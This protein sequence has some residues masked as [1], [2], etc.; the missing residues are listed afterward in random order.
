MNYT[1]VVT[2]GAGYASKVLPSSEAA[3]QELTG[4]RP[5]PG[6]LNLRT[7]RD[8]ALK[9]GLRFQGPDDG[10][11]RMLYPALLG[12]VEVFINRWSGCPPNRID[13]LADKHLR[14]EL[15]LLDGSKIMVTIADQYVALPIVGR[16]RWHLWRILQRPTRSIRRFD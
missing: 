12:D 6:T 13:V 16:L 3:I 10:R 11:V 8:I 4:M 5:H 7:E 15:G 2:T 14:S 9:N 1:A